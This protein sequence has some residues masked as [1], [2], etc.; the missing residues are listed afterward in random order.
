[1]VALQS[2]VMPPHSKE[3]RRKQASALQGT[4][5]R[6]KYFP[7]RSRFKARCS[8]CARTVWSSP[9]AWK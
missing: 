6:P 2:G 4:L 8:A 7:A 9:A 3:A 1:M 5:Q